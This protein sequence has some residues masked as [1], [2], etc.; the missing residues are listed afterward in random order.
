MKKRKIIKI[1][2]PEVIL[3]AELSFF[4]RRPILQTWMESVRDAVNKTHDMYKKKEK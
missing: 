1:E 4:N 2:I 3:D